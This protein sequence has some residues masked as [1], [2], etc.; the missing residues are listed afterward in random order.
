MIHPG[1]WAACIALSGC[2]LLLSA[3]QSG[4]PPIAINSAPSSVCVPAG[5]DAVAVIAFDM[6]IGTDPD[7][8]VEITGVSLDEPSG[9]QLY[10]ASLVEDSADEGVH[11]GLDGDRPGFEPTR[12]PVGRGATARFA[13]QLTGSEAG[14]ARGAWLEGRTSEGEPFRAHTCIGLQVVPNRVGWEACEQ[15]PDLTATMEPLCDTVEI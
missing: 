11:S 1:P 4:P 8:P 2:S 6:V 9:L 14:S 5:E 7:G 13:L 12:L 3:C 10:G 15:Q